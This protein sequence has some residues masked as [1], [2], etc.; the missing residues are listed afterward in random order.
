VLAHHHDG[1]PVVGEHGGGGGHELRRQ[2]QRAGDVAEL[3][4]LAGRPHVED[5]SPQS[6]QLF[7]LLGRHVLVRARAAVYSDGERGHDGPIIGPARGGAEVRGITPSARG[8]R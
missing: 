2:Q 5:D 1:A 6:Q 3:L 4:V 8:A 7:R